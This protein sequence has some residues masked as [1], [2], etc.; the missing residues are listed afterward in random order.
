MGH[1]KTF[2]FASVLLVVLLNQTT[3]VKAQGALQIEPSEGFF[4]SRKNKDADLLKPNQVTTGAKKHVGPLD[5]QTLAW[6]LP[7]EVLP[8]EYRVRIA[9]VI[10]AGQTGVA[11]QWFA[12][13]DVNITVTAQRVTSNIVLHSSNITINSL[14]VSIGFYCF[15]T[16]STQI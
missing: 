3:F 15:C 1:F 11:E 7:R 4:Q 14:T 2:V 12:P 9:P 16:G 6:R 13:G 8:S 10:D 5:D